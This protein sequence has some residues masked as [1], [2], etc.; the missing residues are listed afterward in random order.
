[1][2]QCIGDH[3]DV[4]IHLCSSFTS[5]AWDCSDAR[6]LLTVRRYPEIRAT[7]HTFPLLPP[8]T[9]T[10]LS[11]VSDIYVFFF[12]LWRQENLCLLKSYINSNLTFLTHVTWPCILLTV[13]SEVLL[14]ARDLWMDWWWTLAMD[15][16]ARSTRCIQTQRDK[17]FIIPHMALGM[18]L[19]P[20]YPGR[21]EST[22]SSMPW[23]AERC[24]CVE[25]T[26]FSKCL[27]V[28]QIVHSEECL[29]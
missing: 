14:G 11:G 24:G 18:D 5:V 4:T 26:R 25:A 23:A 8:N 13:L 16:P 9:V 19:R 3:C 20:G 27:M 2:L 1:M 7:N 17:T 28:E 10:A 6:V 15:P 22:F 29:W 12:T 21:L